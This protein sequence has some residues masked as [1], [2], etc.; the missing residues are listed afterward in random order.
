MCDA[1][2]VCCEQHDVAFR[3][4]SSSCSQ[5]Y[6]AVQ[7]QRNYATACAKPIQS[8]N[9]QRFRRSSFKA[10][11]LAGIGRMLEGVLP[12]EFRDVI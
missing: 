11:M 4:C 8:S 3:E 7:S 1:G 10:P 2:H 9:F 5:K 12:V 6:I